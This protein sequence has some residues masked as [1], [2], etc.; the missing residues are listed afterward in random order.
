MARKSIEERVQTVMDRAQGQLQKMAD[1][2]R[3]TVLLPFC[4][5]HGFE[6]DGSMGTSTFYREGNPLSDS[7]LQDEGIAGLAGIV[8]DL[9]VEVLWGQDF[10]TLIEA[11]KAKDMVQS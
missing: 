4:Q 8:A 10:G 1:N 11:V 5:Q 2:Y 3:A 7:D 6:F 9:A